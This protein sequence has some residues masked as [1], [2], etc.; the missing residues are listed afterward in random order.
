MEA[1]T[2]RAPEVG[3]A[4]FGNN[5]ASANDGDTCSGAGGT[6]SGGDDRS[7][8]SGSG[9]ERGFFLLLVYCARWHLRSGF[10]PMFDCKK[11][12]DGAEYVLSL[13][14]TFT[15]HSSVHV[16]MLGSKS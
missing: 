16:C 2:I 10:L 5:A 14:P 4:L 7:S 6:N 13:D 8:D 12:Q 1:E 3:I 15:N 11:N 9:S